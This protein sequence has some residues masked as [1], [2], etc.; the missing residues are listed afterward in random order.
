[1]RDFVKGALILAVLAP[2]IFVLESF[3]Y[4]APQTVA[5]NGES[6]RATCL[7]DGGDTIF[8]GCVADDFRARLDVNAIALR[9]LMFVRDTVPDRQRHYKEADAACRFKIN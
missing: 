4:G 7:K 5:E 1:M 9:R 3:F 2:F 8:C 6:V